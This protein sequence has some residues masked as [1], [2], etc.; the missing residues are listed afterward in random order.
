MGTWFAP[1]NGSKGTKEDGVEIQRNIKDG[2]VV[3]SNRGPKW[4]GI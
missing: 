1:N 3:G 2:N 4:K